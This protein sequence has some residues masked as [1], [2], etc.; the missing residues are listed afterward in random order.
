MKS[1]VVVTPPSIYQ[2]IYIY[3]SPVASMYGDHLH[4]LGDTTLEKKGFQMVPLLFSYRLGEIY[5][6]QFLNCLFIPF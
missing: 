1:I 4:D 6:I 3:M 5:T 2:Y